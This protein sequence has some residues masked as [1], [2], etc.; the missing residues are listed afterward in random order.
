MSGRARPASRRRPV[1]RRAAGCGGCGGRLGA[2]LMAECGAT[3]AEA[4]RAL[5]AMAAFVL[6][7]VV[8]VPRLMYLFIAPMKGWC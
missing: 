5:A 4:A 1:R 2:W 6:L 3:P 7:L 8:V